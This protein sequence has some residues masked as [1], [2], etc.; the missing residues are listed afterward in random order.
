SSTTI[1]CPTSDCTSVYVLPVAVRIGVQLA[2]PESQS[3]H[4]SVTVVGVLAQVP[5]VNVSVSPTR[6]VPLTD[7]WPPDRAT[8]HAVDGDTPAMTQPVSSHGQTAVR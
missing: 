7:G 6:A 2:P 8:A 3:C 5:W 4:T 1:V